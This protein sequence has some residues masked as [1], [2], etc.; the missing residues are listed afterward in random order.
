MLSLLGRHSSKL[1]LPGT[2]D[3]FNGAAENLPTLEIALLQYL[4]FAAVDQV[5]VSALQGVC[6]STLSAFFTHA[7]LMP[8]VHLQDQ[9]PFSN[10][11]NSKTTSTSAALNPEACLGPPKRLQD[12]TALTKR[13]HLVS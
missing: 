9:D 3:D 1:R 8:A 13:N 2:S 5:F 4:R 6:L 10:T 7:L 12:A 11:R